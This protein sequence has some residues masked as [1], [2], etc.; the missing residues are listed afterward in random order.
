[1]SRQSR[2]KKK[3]KQKQKATTSI[4][5]I[6]EMT[7]VVFL[8]PVGT[9]THQAVLQQFKQDDQAD[10]AELIPLKTIPDCFSRVMEDESVDY[11]VVPFENSTNGQVVFTYD[12]IR[13]NIIDNLANEDKLDAQ[14]NDSIAGSTETAHFATRIVPPL[15]IVA[16]QYVP[17]EHCLVTATQELGELYSQQDNDGDTEPVYENLYSHPQVWGQV[18]QY[19]ENHL[20]GKFLNRIDCTSTAEAIKMALQDYKLYGKKSLA[21]GSKIGAMLNNAYII[22]EGINDLKGNTTRFLVLQKGGGLA[23]IKDPQSKENQ[24]LDIRQ[25]M[26]TLL[27]FTTTREGPGSLVDVLNIFQKY[28]INMTSISSRPLG[29]INDKN[30][31]YIFFVEYEYNTSLP[32]KAE[33]L[34]QIDAKCTFWC[35]WGVFN[36][37]SA[38][39]KSSS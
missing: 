28:N 14:K 35:M 34:S 6:I 3:K 25:K 20:K 19:M 12:L 10:C 18:S 17:I 30:W 9:Y 7:K 38:Y 4:H 2:I 29:S 32:W 24:L 39:Y 15:T 11:C 16:E 36:R 22:Q 8:G 21:I 26:M 5:K 37:N 13:D 27:T 33:I 23:L 31:S 1:M